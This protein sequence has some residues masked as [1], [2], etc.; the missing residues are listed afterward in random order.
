MEDAVEGEESRVLVPRT[1]LD[2]CRT[3]LHPRTE[4]S[5]N[6]WNSLEG[7]RRVSKVLEGPVEDAVEGEESRVLVPLVLV[8]IS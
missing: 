6:V 5:R 8:R 7:S 4:G 3:G 2:V 1:N